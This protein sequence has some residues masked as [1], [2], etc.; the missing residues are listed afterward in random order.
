[1][2]VFFSVVSLYLSGNSFS[3]PVEAWDPC[4]NI[5][6]SVIVRARLGYDHARPTV[7]R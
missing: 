5:L 2:Q 6:V 7:E 3:L 4:V 1:M